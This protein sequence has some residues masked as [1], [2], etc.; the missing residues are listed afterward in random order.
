MKLS[1]DL[2]LYSGLGILFAALSLVPMVGVYGTPMTSL[3]DRV[4]VLGTFPLVSTLLFFKYWRLKKNLNDRIRLRMNK[5]IRHAQ[6]DLK[7]LDR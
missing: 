5:I 3:S 4:M 6:V 1:G 7:T 2:R